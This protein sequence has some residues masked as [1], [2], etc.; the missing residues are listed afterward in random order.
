MSD[1]IDLIRHMNLPPERSIKT[2][3][4]LAQGGACCGTCG[5]FSHWK[6][7]R[8]TLKDKHVSSYN[9]CERWTDMK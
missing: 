8:C 3:T 9:I 2:A 1:H 7:G 4:E 6:N 5:Y